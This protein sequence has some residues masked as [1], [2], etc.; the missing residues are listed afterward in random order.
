MQSYHGSPPACRSFADKITIAGHRLRECPVV[1]RHLAQQVSV[2]V[3]VLGHG[4]RG[5]AGGVGFNPASMK[6][7]TVSTSLDAL[8]ASG[9]PAMN[10][11]ALQ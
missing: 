3:V 11:M 9:A 6:R 8:A 5:A 7:M 1:L 10:K 2:V 4:R